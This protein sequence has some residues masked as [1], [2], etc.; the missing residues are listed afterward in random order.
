MSRCLSPSRRGSLL[1]TLPLPLVAEVPRCQ[2]N[3]RCPPLPRQHPD[4]WRNAVIYQV[5]VRSFQDSDG[6]GI[7]DLA[8]VRA[9]LP[10]LRSLG[11]DGIWLNPFYP[12]P[13]HDHGYD[14][15][16]Y[17]GVHPEYGTLESFDRLVHDAHRLDLK[18]LIDVVPNHCSIEHPWFAAALAAGP[19]S[20]ER[21]AVP[22]RRRP[23]RV[24]RAA[25]EQLA[26]DLRRIRLAAGHRAGRTAGQWYLHS[27][28]PEQADFNWRHPDV[29]AYFEEV[30]RF[31]FDRGV[32]GLRIDV[33]HG[34]HKADGLPDHEHA[35]RRRAHRRPD[36]P[37]RLEPAR[38]ARGVAQLA[39]HR[40]GV[41]RADR[42]RAGPDRRG[43]RAG[44]RAARA[45]PAPGRAAPDLLLRVP[46]RRLGRPDAVRRDRPRP[47]ARSPGPAR[48]SPGC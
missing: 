24:R 38:G 6:D 9:R 26:L 45:V 35:D 12:S 30:L 27:F 31:W 41:H 37:A 46:P 44:H 8:G 5:Y 22:L 42:P 48:R 23:R 28:A 43:R 16:D 3:C 10:Y 47:R 13:Q 34:L 7:G 19:G 39:S 18:V 17:R 20:A 2:P 11:V 15:S 40:G 25:A 36:Q 33:A 4:W 29:A 1:T 32:D 21:G 14:V